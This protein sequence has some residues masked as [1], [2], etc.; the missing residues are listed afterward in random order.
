MSCEFD[1]KV[2]VTAETIERLS[3]LQEQLVNVLAEIDK[4]APVQFLDI[5]S[6]YVCNFIGLHVSEDDG[7][8]YVQISGEYDNLPAHTENPLRNGRGRVIPPLDT[9]TSNN[10]IR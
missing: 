4:I 9:E 7:R 1:K 3:E 2:P 10:R 8:V 5:D 6:D